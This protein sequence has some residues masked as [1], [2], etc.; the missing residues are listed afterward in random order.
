MYSKHIESVFRKKK[1]R[2]GDRIFIVKKGKRI[3]GL[4]M[5]QSN[6]GDPDSV[7]IKLDSGYN[8]GIKYESGT[9]IGKKKKGTGIPEKRHELGKLHP[10]Y[11]KKLRYDKNK[12][13][14]SIIHTGGTIASVVDYEIGGV[15]SR[16]TPEDLMQ[17]FPEL[18]DIANI[19]TRFIRNMWS[20][21]MRF[22]HYKILAMEIEKEIKKG[23][24][25]I[26]VG[27]G[28]D[29]MHYTA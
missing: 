1:I 17:M 5:P 26:I 2:T 7:V 12:P 24:K 4:L 6:L 21:D 9:E 11:K 14:I 23:V 10:R 22:E 16:F 28:T 15:V 19:R 18:F 3:E 20:E 8:I 27:H 25:G 29:T 13:T